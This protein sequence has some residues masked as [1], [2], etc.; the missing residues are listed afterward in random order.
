[1]L[2]RSNVYDGFTEEELESE[3][4]CNFIKDKIKSKGAVIML[5][6]AAAKAAAEGGRLHSIFR[7]VT[8]CRLG[9]SC[10]ISVVIA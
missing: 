10:Q 8:G 3:D 7:R 2:F 6:S 9:A 1:M 4:S 5:A